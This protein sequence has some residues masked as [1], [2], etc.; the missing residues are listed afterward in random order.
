MKAIVRKVSPSFKKALA[1]YFG[2]GPT[3]LNEAIRQHGAYVNKLIEFGV[4]VKVIDSDSDFPDCCFVEDHVIVAGDSA[5]LTNAGHDSRLGERK[6]VEQ[7]LNDDLNLEYM[8]EGARMDGGDVLQFGDKFLVGHSQ[9]TNRQGIE[10][11]DKFLQKRDYRLHVVEVPPE[12]LHLISICTSPVLGKLLV[13][14]G[15]FNE[16]DFPEDSEIIWVPTE[17]AYAANV[18]PFGNKV[19]MAKGYPFT[20]KTLQNLDLEVHEMEMSQ[21]REA[22]GSLTCLSVLYD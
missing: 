17:E 5:L 12:S 3:D 14:R 20:F 22:D 16:S 21:F 11:L 2:S 1:K 15:W 8:T 10:D 18:L 19:M 4:S 13:P 6:E 9:R 7:A